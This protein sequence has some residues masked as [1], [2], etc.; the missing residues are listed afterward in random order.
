MIKTPGVWSG[1]KGEGNKRSAQSQGEQHLIILS[2]CIHLFA[3]CMT[4]SVREVGNV[5]SLTVM[6]DKA[7]SNTC[8]FDTNPSTSVF[9]DDSLERRGVS[10]N[11]GVLGRTQP[12]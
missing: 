5:L 8:V 1:W 6:M 2:Q 12:I 9:K 7:S 10:C 4:S 11:P 3:F